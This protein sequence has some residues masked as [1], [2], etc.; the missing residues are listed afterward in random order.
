VSGNPTG[1]PFKVARGERD[2]HQGRVFGDDEGGESGGE[3]EKKEA[4]ISIRCNK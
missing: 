3:N 1:S 4:S 2:I